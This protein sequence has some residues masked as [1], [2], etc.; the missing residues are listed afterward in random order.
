MSPYRGQ[1]AQQAPSIDWMKLTMPAKEKTAPSHSA[2]G[3]DETM[4]ATR[5]LR[6]RAIAG[7]WHLSSD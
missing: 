6:G 2:P 3:T 1:A 7:Q 4:A 5:D